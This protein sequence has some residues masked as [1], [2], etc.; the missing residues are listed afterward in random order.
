[1]YG[2]GEEQ[3][4]RGG[5]D[6]REGSDSEA[7]LGLDDDGVVVEGSRGREGRGNGR[8]STAIG[9]KGLESGMGRLYREM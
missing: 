3:N 1:M 4:G 9:E 8:V 6:G 2:G 5:L 7:K